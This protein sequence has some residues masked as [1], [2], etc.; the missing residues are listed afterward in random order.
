[1]TT[2]TPGQPA[3]PE[4]ELRY[5]FRL[6]GLQLVPAARVLTELV[7][8]AQVYPVPRGPAALAG[9]INLHGTIVPLFDPALIGRPRPDIRPSR[10]L[11]L[12]FD[13]DEQRA[14]LLVDA[15]PELLRLV[16][17]GPARAPSG[18]LAASVRRAWQA[19]EGAADT[20]WE[21]D[22]RAAFAWLAASP[23]HIADTHDLPNQVNA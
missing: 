16:P 17:A 14:G 5:G 9:V 22:H 2:E 10:R 23:P 11:A 7:G 8:D 21:F 6:A 20:W 15:A 3:A 18:P 1:M 19:A 12:V 4:G 13:R